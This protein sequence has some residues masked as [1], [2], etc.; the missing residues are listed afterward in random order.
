MNI[1][2]YTHI[3]YMQ[4]ADSLLGKD[5]DDYNTDLHTCVYIHTYTH[6]YIYTHTYIHT[7]THEYTYIHT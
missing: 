2:T 7:Y 5:W 1:H 6:E 4:L 3:T